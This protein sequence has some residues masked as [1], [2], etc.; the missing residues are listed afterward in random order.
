MISFILMAFATSIPELFVGV[1]AAL[2]N[3]PIIS[4]GNVLGSNIVNLSLILGISVLLVRKI[5]IESKTIRNDF[6][7]SAVIGLLPFALIVDGVLSKIDGAILL[8]VFAVYLYFLFRRRRLFHGSTEENHFLK[9]CSLNLFIFLVSVATLIISAN[10]VVTYGTKVALDLQIPVIL[11]SLF[12]I[13]LGTSLPELVFSVMTVAEKREMTLGNLLGSTIM[14]A[15]LVLGITALITPIVILNFSF[16]IKGIVAL[17]LIFLVLLFAV[18][19]KKELG[20]MTAILLLV[21]YLGFIVFE[22][23][24]F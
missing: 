22:F 1:S 12:L 19:T 11:V 4:L 3:Q 21:I 5:K 18:N 9:G 17:G 8:V 10:Y 2:K 14:N 6:L 20:R 7:Y 23:W 16:L 15:S 13:A 24:S